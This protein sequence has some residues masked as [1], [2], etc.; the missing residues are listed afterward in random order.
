MWA[1]GA[2]KEM[3][4]ILK[5]MGVLQKA[6]RSFKYR[7]VIAQRCISSFL[8]VTRARFRIQQLQWATMHLSW[9][10]AVAE[11]QAKLNK[12]RMPPT[13]SAVY[14]R[15][16]GHYKGYGIRP[17]AFMVKRYCN[18]MKSSSLLALIV[19]TNAEEVPCCTALL[20]IRQLWQLQ[21]A[22]RQQFILRRKAVLEGNSGVKEKE[23]LLR[24]RMKARC[25]LCKVSVEEKMQFEES[26]LKLQRTYVRAPPFPSTMPKSQIL[27][28]MA[29]YVT[30]AA[31]AAAAASVTV[32]MEVAGD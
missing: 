7:V 32:K 5:S 25:L 2:V 4:L 31:A 1:V 18:F 22:M 14:Q 26:V 16:L 12:T 30:S 20:V 21:K 15:L 19:D 24:I 28:V 27:Q 9:A 3:L 23:A 17:S 13:V 29:E 11:R 8:A 6:V 10:R